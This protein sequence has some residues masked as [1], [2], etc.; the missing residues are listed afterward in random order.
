MFFKKMFPIFVCL[1]KLG[2]ECKGC[3]GDIIP[4]LYFY[5]LVTWDPRTFWKPLL[6]VPMLGPVW[7]LVCLW[8]DRNQLAVEPRASRSTCLVPLA[9]CLPDR[10]LCGLGGTRSYSKNEPRFI[11]EHHKCCGGGPEVALV[12]MGPGVGL[13]EVNLLSLTKNPNTFD[14]LS[15][16]SSQG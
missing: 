12:W 13:P 9:K 5:R 10:H 3:H 2:V 1:G 16:Q 8:S 14:R 4:P 6:I 15:R 11:R 7:G